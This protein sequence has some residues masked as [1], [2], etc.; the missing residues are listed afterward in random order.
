MTWWCWC[1]GTGSLKPRSVRCQTKNSDPYSTCST[2]SDVWE[3]NHNQFMCSLPSTIIGSTTRNQNICNRA[4]A[5]ADLQIVPKRSQTYKSSPSSHP[6]IL[7]N[8]IRT[9]HHPI[10]QF[11]SCP[12]PCLHWKRTLCLFP[13]SHLLSSTLSVQVVRLGLKDSIQKSMENSPR[14]NS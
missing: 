11:E 8:S 7:R 4:I 14:K 13:P 1:S 2:Y 3:K 10:T 9:D 12:T 6:T 5:I